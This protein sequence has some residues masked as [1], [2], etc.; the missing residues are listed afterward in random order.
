MKNITIN[1]QNN[2]IELS[3]SFAKTASTYGTKAYNELMNA[4][5]DFPEFRVDV[6]KPVSKRKDTFKG[7]DTK[8]MEKYIIAHSG[9]ESEQMK[10]FKQLRGETGCDFAKKAT[11]GQIK[12]WFLEQYP[13]LVEGSKNVKKALKVS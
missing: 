1:F 8:Y 3:A 6:V 10:T 2:T 12:K 4:R 7:L 13:E 5:H 9:E 11:Y